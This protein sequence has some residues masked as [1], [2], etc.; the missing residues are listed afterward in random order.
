MASERPLTVES[1]RD[2]RACLRVFV[3][4]SQAPS[5]YTGEWHFEWFARERAWLLTSPIG[6]TFERAIQQRHDEVSGL[7]GIVGGLPLRSI[8]S[9][10]ERRELFPP[11]GWVDAD[12]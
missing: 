8:A 7:L 2:H 10:I 9:E 12:P 6:Q 5:G 1:C 3:P 4:K 11:G